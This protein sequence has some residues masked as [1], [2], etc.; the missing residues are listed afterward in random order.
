MA[1]LNGDPIGW[2]DLQATA[3]T[4]YKS[5]NASTSVIQDSVSGTPTITSFGAGGGGGGGNGSSFIIWHP[6]DGQAPLKAEEFSEEVYEFASGITQQ[7]RGTL[8][9]PTSYAAGN[10][11]KVKFSEYSPDTSGT[12]VIVCTTDLI[13]KATD[14]V[15][16]TTNASTST[17]TVTLGSPANIYNEVSC[18]VTDASGKINSVSVNPGDILAIYISRTTDTATSDA[19]ILPGTTE[20]TF[21]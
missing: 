19:R 20:V 11:I 14:A 6:V 8:K 18:A 21:Q 10:P 7:L 5:A 9:V 2:V 13:R 4:A 15:S 12:N 16:S 1:S 3:G 17:I